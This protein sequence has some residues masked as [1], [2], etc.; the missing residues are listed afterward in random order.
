MG[1]NAGRTMGAYSL[2]EKYI[3]KQ[4]SQGIRLVILQEREIE[5]F[6]VT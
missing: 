2:R 1:L 6:E 3:D 5:T 4:L